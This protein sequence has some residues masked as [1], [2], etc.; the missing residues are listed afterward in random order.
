ML[1]HWEEAYITIKVNTEALL[2]ASR[3]IGLEVNTDKSL[4]CVKIRR[5]DQV[6]IIPDNNSFERA[7]EFKH[8]DTTLTDQNFIQEKIRAD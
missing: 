8:F 4:L 2:M 1:I 3:E 7:E 5:Q 6:K